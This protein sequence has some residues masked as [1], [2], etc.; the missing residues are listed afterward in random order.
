MIVI[1]M[2]GLLIRC[3]VFNV[4]MVLGDGRVV[5]YRVIVLWLMIVVI[6]C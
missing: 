4:K 2:K 6:G 5:I 3:N 1:L